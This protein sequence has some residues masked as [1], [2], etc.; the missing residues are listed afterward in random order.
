MELQMSREETICCAF[1]PHSG[2]IPAPLHSGR[3][4]HQSKSE[5]FQGA[6]RTKKNTTSSQES[7]T[8]EPKLEHWYGHIGISA[9][10]AALRFA[11]CS[12]HASMETADS[13]RDEEQKQDIAA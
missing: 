12:K 13:Q 6:N 8:T 7:R 9:V 3:K 11:S 2:A 5:K 1:R 4:E 10:V